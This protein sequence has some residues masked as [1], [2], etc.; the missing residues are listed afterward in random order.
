MRR[1]PNPNEWPP[2]SMFQP[3]FGQ[4]AAGDV[5]YFRCE[6]V[7]FSDQGT[8]YVKFIN[9]DRSVCDGSSVVAIHPDWIVE[10]TVVVGE[11]AEK[12]KN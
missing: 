1:T 2:P 9:K 11:L 7:G 12:W 8:P 3:R 5:V 10:G 4:R 6:I